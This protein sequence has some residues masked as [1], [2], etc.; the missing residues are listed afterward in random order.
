MKIAVG[1]LHTEC[2]TY[3][4]L[5]QTHADFTIS[6][7]AAFLR[8]LRFPAGLQET[9]DFKP[10]FQARSIPG[11]PIT[12]DCYNSFKQTFL[13]NLKALGDLDGV[14]LIM[15][16]ALNVSGLDDPEGDWISAVRQVVGDDVPIAVS[17][18]LHGN[19]TQKII[20]SIDIF[21]A[22]RTAPHI[23]VAETHERALSELVDMIRTGRKRMVAWT[24]IP[25]LLPGERTSTEDEPAAAL[26]RTLSEFD[27]RTGI[28]D[29]NLM[30]GYVWADDPRATAAA[31]VTGTDATA[32]QKASAEIAQGYWD[33]RSAFN[34]G[35]QTRD[36][37]TCIKLIGS[38]T[39]QPL[40]LADSGDNPTGGGV[41]DRSDVLTAFLARGLEGA[42]FAGIADPRAARA[43]A[44]A[45][46]GNSVSLS[47]GGALGSNCAPV[48]AEANVRCIQGDVDTGNL[49]VAVTI[50]GNTV[51]LT[52]RRRPFH[53]ITDIEIFDIKL[54]TTS[55]LVVKSGYLSPELAPIA[56][57]ALMALTDGAVNQDIQSLENV[58][59]PNP[60]FPF[61]TG[62]DWSP[63]PRISKRAGT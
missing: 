41:G 31:V 34:F 63:S 38:I 27:T 3:S 12:H 11:G 56:N 47:I 6:T 33:H 54:E 7:G 49:E 51:I 30:V 19:V 16:G 45:G 36:L 60:C 44:I 25:V 29:A 15:H 53:H 18:D 42:V 59:R 43:A 35:V 52:E 61:Q 37:K 46:V 4:P 58:R 50:G 28:T 22:Y 2:S 21:A 23:D 40:I 8:E 26:Y 9:V 32:I 62:F 5:H 39:S 17:F 1:G 48:L 57:P 13:T 24:P 55:V 14:L 20:D 10:L